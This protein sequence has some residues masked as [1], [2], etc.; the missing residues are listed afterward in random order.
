VLFVLFFD[1]C[2]NSIIE[3][4]QKLHPTFEPIV[5]PPKPWHDPPPPL[6]PKDLAS[7]PTRSLPDLFAGRPGLEKLLSDFHAE[8]KVLKGE[9]R[10]EKMIAA[11]ATKKLVLEEKGAE[12]ER[13]LRA[14]AIDALERRRRDDRAAAGVVERYM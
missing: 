3:Q 12:A 11:E 7:I 4:Y 1:S 6:P 2:S 8:T 5:P 14:E 9:L 13:V 10:E